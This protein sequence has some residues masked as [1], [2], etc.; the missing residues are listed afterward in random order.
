MIKKMMV[1]SLLSLFLVVTFLA[2]C[3]GGNG[4][5]GG[6]SDVTEG[7]V[8]Y[9]PFNGDANDAIGDADA[10]A[11]GA[12]ISYTEDRFGNSNKACSGTIGS[13]I[14]IFGNRVPLSNSITF[15]AWIKN[16][17]SSNGNYLYCSS[18]GIYFS[19]VNN[20]ISFDIYTTSPLTIEGAISD[21][22]THVVETYDNS[23]GIAALYINGEPISDATS[24]NLLASISLSGLSF[25][26]WDGIIDDLRIYNRVLTANEIKQLYQYHNN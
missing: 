21:E 20:K 19:G 25:A 7:L 8:A 14:S 24:S 9:Y 12:G 3:G 6:V 23:T 5:G 16:T 17:S 4:G 10:S 22:W 15:A 1:Y 2:G 11:V 18:F 13:S 26:S